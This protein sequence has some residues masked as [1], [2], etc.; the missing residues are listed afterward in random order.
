MF[1]AFT[2]GSLLA[3]RGSLVFT[4]NSSLF[5]WY[6]RPAMT[7][8][9]VT[10]KWKRGR[11][12]D[13]AQLRNWFETLFCFE[14][15]GRVGARGLPVCDALCPCTT[16]PARPVADQDYSNWPGQASLHPAPAGAASPQDVNGKSW[17]DSWEDAELYLNL[18]GREWALSWKTVDVQAQ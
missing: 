9:Q 7:R 2:P 5:C 1:T 16:L 14:S 11:P 8:T 4:D 15:D 18:N 13:E 17:K 10:R 3:T 12:C 6:S